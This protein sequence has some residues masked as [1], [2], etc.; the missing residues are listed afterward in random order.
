M[1]PTRIRVL[2][3]KKI[4]LSILAA[5][6]LMFAY[7]CNKKAIPE[8]SIF[9]ELT[10][11]EV[12]TAINAD[13]DF[14]LCYD[15]VRHFNDDIFH[16]PEGRPGPLTDEQIEHFR[17]ITYA[18]F[19]DFHKYLR[20]TTVWAPLHKQWKEEWAKDGHRYD[21]QVDSIINQYRDV[22]KATYDKIDTK[23]SFEQR[24]SILSTVAPLNV[25]HYM[26]AEHHG[27]N[28]EQLDMFRGMIIKETIDPEYVDMFNYID[29]KQTEKMGEKDALCTEFI[30]ALR[31]REGR[32]CCKGEE[33]GCQK[34]CPKYNDKCHKDNHKIAEEVVSCD[35]PESQANQ[36]SHCQKTEANNCAKQEPQTSNTPAGGC[37]KHAHCPHHQSQN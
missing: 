3:M 11:E 36:E 9:D 20:D 7:S 6:F 24:D 17:P 1:F 12:A 10:E 25:V 5:I 21:A 23:V 8:K 33:Q 28:A 22:V 37:G 16:T 30:N 29:A 34:Q 13:A 31:P 18:Q 27:A 4:G 2:K 19:F 14:E 35:E 32:G 26:H 15:I